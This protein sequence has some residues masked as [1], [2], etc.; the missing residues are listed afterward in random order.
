VDAG[1]LAV[2]K[3]AG[4]GV[5]EGE[6]FEQLVE[7]VLLGFGASVGR[8]AVGIETALIDNTEG[9][10]VVALDMNTLDTLG[11]QGDDAAIVAD[12]VVVGALT[13]FGFTTGDQVFYA[14]WS[15]TLG[16]GAMHHK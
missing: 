2:T 10:V 4:S 11:E 16:S 1:E 9:A 3:D 12:V 14:E 8:L 5:V 15:V 13:V 7:G 6:G